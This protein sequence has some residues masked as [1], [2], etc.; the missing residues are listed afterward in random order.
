MIVFYLCER[1]NTSSR[2]LKGRQTQ[3]R[4]Q[5]R[6]ITQSGGLGGGQWE[7]AEDVGVDHEGI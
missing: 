3:V 1:T 6:P 4:E 5:F 7:F 2:R